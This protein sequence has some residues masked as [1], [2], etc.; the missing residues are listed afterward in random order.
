MQDPTIDELA[1]WTLHPGGMEELNSGRMPL[2]PHCTGNDGYDIPS[3][4]FA[5]GF[6]IYGAILMKVYYWYRQPPPPPPPPPWSSQSSLPRPR[7]RRTKRYT[8]DTAPT[9]IDPLTRN[10]H[11]VVDDN[12]IVELTSRV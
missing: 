11:V 10:H 4:G 12:E 5:L 2:P 1:L 6:T 3:I 9:T 8:T 7:P